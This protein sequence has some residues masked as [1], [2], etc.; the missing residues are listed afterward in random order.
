MNTTYTPYLP[1]AIWNILFAFFLI[2]SCVS[3]WLLWD[4]DPSPIVRLAFAVCSSLC[5]FTGKIGHSFYQ[6]WKCLWAIYNGVIRLH[7]GCLI[8]LLIFGV[9]AI[10]LTPVF[11]QA[12][13]MANFSC[14]LSDIKQEGVALITY[15]QDHGDTFP[16]DMRQGKVYNFI[17]PVLT[18]QSLGRPFIWCGEL[19]GLKRND[20]TYPEEVVA[21]YAS[22]PI[23]GWG[24]AVLFLD[25]HVKATP[26]RTTLLKYLKPRQ[27]L[28]YLA[29][30]AHV[31]RS[32]KAIP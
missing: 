14:V 22:Q 27:K 10:V 20:F 11:L 26:T 24:Y 1:R 5:L 16:P 32:L 7:W 12:Q 21:A 17:K 29:K 13:S 28:V 15:A 30:Q 18:K 8:S 19:S 3:G 4:G 23:R 6:I 9:L 31:K 25:G 2:C